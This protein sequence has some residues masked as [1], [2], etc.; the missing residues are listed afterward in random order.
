MHATINHLREV[1]SQKRQ[2]LIRCR[3]DHAVDQIRF[4]RN[5]PEVFTT[6]RDDPRAWQ[7]SV[8]PADPI[9]LQASAVDDVT[10]RKNITTGF[11]EPHSSGI[12]DL[13]HILLKTDV[14]ISATDILRHCLTHRR[15][16]GD[17]GRRHMQGLKARHMRFDFPRPLTADPFDADPI[18]RSV[19]EKAAKGRNL[20]IVVCYNELAAGFHGNA[21]LKAELLHRKRTLL[22][23]LRLEAAGFV[24]NTRV[25]HTRVPS[26]LVSGGGR[27]FFNHHNS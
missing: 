26:A 9:A 13:Q 24:I 27:L 17:S 11:N 5:E 22:A 19:V 12:N 23:V 21:A 1:S 14:T 15:V 8:H 6:E 2:L 4:L 25:N 18:A 20:A 16:T 3:V 10:R 7:A